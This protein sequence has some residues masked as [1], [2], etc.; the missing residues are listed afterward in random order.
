MM[1][2]WMANL[3]DLARLVLRAILGNEDARADWRAMM[4]KS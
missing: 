3:F 4:G 1:P 2:L